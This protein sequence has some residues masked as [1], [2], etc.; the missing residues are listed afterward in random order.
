[1]RARYLGHVTGYKPIR[2]QYFLIRSVP[3]FALPKYDPTIR[4]LHRILLSPLR[5][6]AVQVNLH[7]LNSVD[8]LS[9]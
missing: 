5:L 4:I 2:D 1:M 8:N 7:T 9:E 3:A 6:I